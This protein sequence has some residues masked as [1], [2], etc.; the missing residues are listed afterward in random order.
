MS[1]P[2]DSPELPPYDINN[3]QPSK[4]LSEKCVDSLEESASMDGDGLK[5]KRKQRR[6]RTHFTSYQ[7]QELEAMFSRNR[8][9]DMAVREEIAMWTSL[10]EARVRV[11]FKNRRAKWRKKEKNNP[12]NMLG[13]D[14]SSGIIPSVNGF[15]ESSSSIRYESSET[16]PSVYPNYGANYWSKGAPSIGY[17][18]LQQSSNSLGYNSFSQIPPPC[19]VPPQISGSLSPFSTPMSSDNSSSYAP[20]SSSVPSVPCGY[21]PTYGYQ[22]Q[23]SVYLKGKG[24]SLNHHPNYSQPNPYSSYPYGMAEIPINI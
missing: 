19:P 9:P 1:S 10:T 7:L 22:D 5:Q 8:Y 4:E 23:T 16:P 11:W 21:P 14:K 18:S 3:N 15:F 2:R 12:P 13:Q 20:N 24:S 17:T 6:Q